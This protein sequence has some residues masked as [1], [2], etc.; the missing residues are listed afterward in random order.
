MLRLN[1]REIEESSVELHKL[2]KRQL[3]RIEVSVN[4]LPNDLGKW[5][6]F[7]SYINKTYQENDQDRY[8]LDRS[9]EISSCEMMILNEKLE[10]AEHI[11]HLCYWQYDD[12]SDYIFGS[13][14]LYNIFNPN[15]TAFTLKEFLRNIYKD[16]R[17]KFQLLM[18]K[19]LFEKINFECEIRIKNRENNYG[20]YRVISHY[21]E[22]DNQ[23]T[24]VIIDINKDKE[25]EAKIKELNQKLLVTARCA[26]MSEVA[27]TILH[28]IGN[29]L[30]SSNIS[31]N[32]LKENM[33][34]PYYDKL[35]KIAHMV[36]ENIQDLCLY[37]TQDSKGKLI[38]EYLIALSELIAYKQQENMREIESLEKDLHHIKDIVSIQKSVGGKSS[39]PENI[40][41]PDLIETALHMTSKPSQD[42]FIKMEI[43][44]IEALNIVADKSKLLQ[45]LVNIIQ[46]AKDAV[47]ENQEKKEKKIEFIVNGKKPQVNIQII[48]NGIGI[49]PEHLER[50]FSF[51]F[52]T[53]ENGHGFGLHSSALSAQD[54]G[55][56]LRAESE[57]IGKGAKFILTLPIKET[58]GKE[59][60]VQ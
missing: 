37:L 57:G 50:I 11:G 12:N 43:K 26:G 4:E 48:D 31:L 60:I 10:H 17:E 46:N 32:I 30:N 49:S 6:E 5:Q 41:L 21:Q 18:H 47:L 44:N 51:G 8:L 25:T 3:N 53:K 7:I 14:E 58:Q 39:I 20:W 16:D 28:N 27:T 22:Q 19:S 52:T 38:P 40:F 59:G 45:I 15:K 2:L 9:M 42:K 1:S 56:S 36:K 54:M 23:L 34:K 24:G 29:V 33:S 55:G 35:F 13:K